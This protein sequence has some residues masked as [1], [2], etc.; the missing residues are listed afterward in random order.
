MT[1]M[2]AGVPAVTVTDV[3][4]S[5]AELAGAPVQLNANVN[6]SL[7]GVPPVTLICN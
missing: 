1:L 3:G 4:I 6:V 2:G 7:V 5:Q